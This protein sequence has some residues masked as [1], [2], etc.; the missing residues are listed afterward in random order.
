MLITSSLDILYKTNFTLLMN[1]VNGF[2][3]KELEL[4]VIEPEIILSKN[5]LTRDPSAH[6]VF[7]DDGSFTLKG[8]L[9]ENGL[10]IE[11]SY[12]KFNTVDT[13]VLCKI[14]NVIRECK[15]TQFNHDEVI[16]KI[17]DLLV[18]LV[19]KY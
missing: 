11:T 1:R 3:R 15:F 5:S 17:E 18:N 13:V 2:L 4:G 10:I 7:K 16:Q 6:I 12:D 14:I 9:R 8:T 19:K